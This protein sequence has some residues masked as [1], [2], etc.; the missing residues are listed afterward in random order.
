M[1]ELNNTVSDFSTVSATEQSNPIEVTEKGNFIIPT[2]YNPIIAR[3]GDIN[4]KTITFRLPQSYGQ[5][6]LKTCDYKRI[7]WKNM[8][9][10]IEDTS[11]LTVIENETSTTFDV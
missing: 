11:Q 1:E 8:K 6:S 3:E 2:G 9:S 4:S 7:K 5:Y 10:L